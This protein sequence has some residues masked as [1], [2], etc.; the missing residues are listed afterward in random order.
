[1]R[2]FKTIYQIVLD[3][4]KLVLTKIKPGISLVELNE[5]AKDSL[6][7]G[8]LKAGLIKDKSEISKYYFHSV[9]HHLGLDTH[10]PGDRK[11]PLVAGNVIT[12]EPGLYFKELGIGVRIEDDVLVTDEGSYCLSGGIIKEIDDIERAMGSIK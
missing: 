4:N 5:I 10:D 8:C 2:Y 11:V 12:D 7:E 1:M 3:T 9:G 6:A